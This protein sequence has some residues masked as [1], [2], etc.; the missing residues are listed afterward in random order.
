MSCE[1]ENKSTEIDWLIDA[2]ENI[3][4]IYCDD[5]HKVVGVGNLV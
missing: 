5:C 3:E 2:E 4:V 1:H